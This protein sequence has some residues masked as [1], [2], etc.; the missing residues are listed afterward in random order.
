MIVL[1]A[2][3]F[4]DWV[5]NAFLVGIAYFAILGPRIQE[6]PRKKDFFLLFVM[7]AF[8]G[9]YELPAI[10]SLDAAITVRNPEIVRFF[11]LE[12]NAPLI[13]LYSIDLFD[14]FVWLAQS[15]VAIFVGGKVH[16]RFQWER[17]PNQGT[18]T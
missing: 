13:E 5:L 15:A 18:E 16:G 1:G 14:V 3:V 2:T 9:V 6:P 12:P 7:F 11:E 10:L 4:L 17:K 8:L